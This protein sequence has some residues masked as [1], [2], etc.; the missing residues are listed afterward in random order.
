MNEP[1]AV[2]GYDTYFRM[3]HVLGIDEDTGA[4][5]CHGRWIFETADPEHLI[6]EGAGVEAKEN[7]YLTD[8]K[9]RYFWQTAGSH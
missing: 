7:R 8:G 6:P 1:S 9:H 5:V 4:R 2:E 3:A